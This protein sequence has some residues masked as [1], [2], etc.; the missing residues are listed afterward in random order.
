MSE[1]HA[2]NI[3]SRPVLACFVLGILF[4]AAVPGAG[5]LWGQFYETVVL[6]IGVAFLV[7]VVFAYIA[8]VNRRLA[9][10]E[11]RLADR[12]RARS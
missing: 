7:Y 9:A 10:L 11:Q 1:P 5:W 6:C 2:P 12:D 8:A 4:I 3:A